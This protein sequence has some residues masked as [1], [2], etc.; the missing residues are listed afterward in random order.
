MELSAEDEPWREH[1]EQ[2]RLQEV[3]NEKY[4]VVSFG[5]RLET[6][7]GAATETIRAGEGETCRR[8]GRQEI[9][10]VQYRRALEI[11]QRRY[12]L[13]LEEKK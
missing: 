7:I 5:A 3:I 2:G 13:Y 10:R 4:C 11:L 8:C 9:I 12:E 1:I 6:C